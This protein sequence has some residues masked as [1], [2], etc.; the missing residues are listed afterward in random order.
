MV[1]EHP[2]TPPPPPPSSQRPSLVLTPTAIGIAAA[3]TTGQRPPL[4]PRTRHRQQRRELARRAQLNSLRKY[5]QSL[6][7]KVQVLEADNARLRTEHAA[8]FE[9]LTGVTPDAALDEALAHVALAAPSPTV[10]KGA[11]ED[12]AG[13]GVDAGGSS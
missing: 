11:A 2:A 3:H 10:A 9:A 6:Q 8:A 4:A 7:A 5:I 1:K 13:G 12:A